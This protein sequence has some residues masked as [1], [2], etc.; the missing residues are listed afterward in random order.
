[1]SRKVGQIIARGERTWLVRVY[2][3]RPPFS[4]LYCGTVIH[5][6]KLTSR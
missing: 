4:I 5:R 3:G 6:P 2:L 1:M